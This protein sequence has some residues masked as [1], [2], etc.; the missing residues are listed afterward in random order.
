MMHPG[1]GLLAR[2]GQQHGWAGT[3]AHCGAHGAG[4][5]AARPAASGA[6]R[7]CVSVRALCCVWTGRCCSTLC[8]YTSAALA[9]PWAG[10]PCPAGG[11]P[12][13]VRC[14]DKV[15]STYHKS[16]LG[17][18]VAGAAGAGAWVQVTRAAARV[19]VCGM[20]ATSHGS[21]VCA[22]RHSV[23]RVRGLH[24]QPL[25]DNSM[26]LQAQDVWP[27]GL[28]PRCAEDLASGS[29]PQQVW[30]VETAGPGA[31]Q[32]QQ[33]GGR[34]RV[35]VVRMLASRVG[36]LGTPPHAAACTGVWLVS[37]V[38]P[39]A[40]VWHMLLGCAGPRRCTN[41]RLCGAGACLLYACGTCAGG[42]ASFWCVARCC[43]GTFAGGGR[44]IHLHVA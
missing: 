27:A 26:K 33:A 5:R 30:L 2:T 22:V 24:H 41:S 40:W 6:G 10:G 16:M 17:D 43:C 9:P 21:F 38:P 42:G 11:P 36:L 28:C 23:T 4:S 39:G 7:V 34:A 37:L 35:C 29:L 32:L 15:H 14:R 8:R 12:S 18:Q 1:R 3:H 31:L 20:A 13:S 25:C 44:H 19:S